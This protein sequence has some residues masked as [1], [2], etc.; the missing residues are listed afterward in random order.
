MQGGVKHGPCGRG[1][2]IIASLTGRFPA[3]R[4]RR[5]EAI[6]FFSNLSARWTWVSSSS[7]AHGISSHP[8]NRS[9]QQLCTILVLCCV[10]YCTGQVTIIVQ[11]R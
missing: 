4:R 5:P 7:A 3:L 10:K 6:L 1:R 11:I 9:T 8:R 2:D